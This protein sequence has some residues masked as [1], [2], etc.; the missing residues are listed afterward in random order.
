VGIGTTSPTQLQM[1][2]SVVQ[3]VS[4]VAVIRCQALISYYS[5]FISNYASDFNTTGY[6][7]LLTSSNANNLLTFV[8]SSLQ[9]Y[10]HQSSFIKYTGSIGLRIKFF[11]TLFQGVSLANSYG[12]SDYLLENA[13]SPSQT[14]IV[15]SNQVSFNDG[16]NQVCNQYGGISPITVNVGGWVGNWNMYNNSILTCNT[17][18]STNNTDITFEGL[19]TGDVILKTGNSNRLTISDSGDWTI[20]GSVGT[21]NQVL[22]SGGTG[23]SPFWNSQ[24]VSP[25]TTS[26]LSLTGNA[27]LLSETAGSSS[28]QYLVVIVNGV[29]YKI[30]LLNT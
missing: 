9:V 18:S 29:S 21:N 28:G 16:N 19:G 30:A 23:V 8:G 17:V 5:T 13:S 12:A 6:V 15:D 2:Q 27:A 1:S 25:V 22:T 11:N 7:V 4:E 14:I 24:V 20:N 10:R 26:G 3:G